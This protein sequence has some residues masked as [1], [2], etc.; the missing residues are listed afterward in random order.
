MSTEE[1]T[2]QPES[3][4][5]EAI[6]GVES[7]DSAT[8]PVGSGTDSA[9][10]VADDGGGE[11]QDAPKDWEKEAKHFQR[12]HDK[13][14]ETLVK[15][16]KP[17]LDAYQPQQVAGFVSFL[18]KA[19]RNP[20]MKEILEHFESYG[21]VPKSVRSEGPKEGGNVDDD[22]DDFVS[23]RD[24]KQALD[25]A[26]QKISRLE[27]EHG[28][29]LQTLQKGH[30]DQAMKESMR[31]FMDQYP[32]MTTEE[33]QEFAESLDP[34][35]S[36]LAQTSQGLQMLQRMDDDAFKSLAFPKME[37]FLPDI[38]ARRFKNTKAT[39][40]NGSTDGTSRVSATTGQEPGST[41]EVTTDRQ[42]LERRAAQIAREVAQGR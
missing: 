12:L 8:S 11:R 26:N 29:Q 13:Q 9:A 16:L 32:E 2:P 37:R 40:A 18:E 42:E 17:V 5:A 27:N 20:G 28:S 14:H 25:E 22:P 7:T 10:P 3:T 38:Y 36:R 41:P 31:R 39:R 23:R 15:P 1:T 24:L 30:G 4:A 35:W 21:D 33:R 19:Y 34:V 6:P